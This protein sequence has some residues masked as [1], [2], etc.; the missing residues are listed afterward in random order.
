[1]TDDLGD[2]IVRRAHT[3]DAIRLGELGALLV[4]EHHDFDGQRFI[5]AT[6]ETAR[7]YGAFLSSQLEAAD[8]VI[9]VAE[10]PGR[11]LGYAYAAIQGFDY[12][13]LRG[14][15]AVLQDLIIEPESRGRG[16]GRTLLAA[17]LKAMKDRGA[18]RIV[19]STAWRNEGAQR[20]FSRTGFRKTMVEM[21]LEWSELK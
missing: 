5:A 13:A 6:G 17:I 7:R 19:L 20:L 3:D 18:P 10:I 8:A 12:M 9:L 15:A 21:T 14:P 16:I 11:V 2:V 1:M 4:R